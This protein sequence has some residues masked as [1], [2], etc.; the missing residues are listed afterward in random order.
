MVDMRNA[1]KILVRKTEDQRPLVRKRCRSK[2]N[3]FIF[4]KYDVF[5]WIRFNCKHDF[6][7]KHCPLCCVL[8]NITF[9]NFIYLFMVCVTMLSDAQARILVDRIMSE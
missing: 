7:F 8:S 6:Y 1:Y 3:I 9:Q 2:A 4:K 5:V